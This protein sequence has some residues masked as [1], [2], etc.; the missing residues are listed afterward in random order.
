MNRRRA[1]FLDVDGTLVSWDGLVPDSA[2]DAVRAARANGHLVFVCTGRSRAEMWPDL[3]DIGFDGIIGASGAYVSLGEEV[4]FHQGIPDADL[5]RALAWFAEHSTEVVL[6]ADDVILAPPHVRDRMR[7]SVAHLAADPE[8]FARGSFGFVDRVRTDGDRTGVDVTKIVYLG[9]PFS[10][11]EVAAAF[12]GVFDVLPSSVEAFGPGCGEV[13]VAGTDKARGL[14][15][16][17]EHLG[18]DRADTIAIGD[19][20]NDLTLLRRAGLG[21]AMGNAHP[22]VK[23]AADEVTGRVDEDGLAQA[24]AKHGLI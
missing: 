22:E 4:L 18:L 14:D 1:V 9:S 3:L 11:E 12:A 5:D 24:F 2:V 8:A 23:A 16:I 13:T 15:V 21:I 6:Q 19:S 7:E 17:V 20:W 10:V